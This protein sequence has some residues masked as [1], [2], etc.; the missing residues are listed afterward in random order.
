MNALTPAKPRIS[1]KIRAA[2]TLRVKEGLSWEEC[3]RRA[4]LSEAGLHKARRRQDVANLEQA[5]KL[6]FIQHIDA[7]KGIYKARAL[8]HADYLSRNATSEAVQARMVE[9]LAGEARSGPSVNVQIN[10]NAGG[11]YEYVRPGQVIEIVEVKA[12]APDRQSGGENAQPTDD[13]EE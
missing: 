11:G 13:N 6:A 1:P 10:Q 8:Q 2:I 9:F 12:S 7:Q 3:A 4:G 5:E